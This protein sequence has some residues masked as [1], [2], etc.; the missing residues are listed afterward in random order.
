MKKMNWISDFLELIEAKRTE[1]FV[2][3]V[4]DC[5]LFAADCVMVMGNPDP[6][7]VSRGKYST[8]IGAKKHLKSVYGDIYKAWDGKLERLD[9]INFVQNGDVVVYESELGLTSGIYW[10]GGVFAPSETGVVL[11]TEKHN[12]LL[13]AWRV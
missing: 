5:V 8:E 6:A 3:G 7:E 1:A 4:N 13:A 10:H 2:W 12:Q 9:N 11:V